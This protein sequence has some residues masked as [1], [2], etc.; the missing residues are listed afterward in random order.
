MVI[1]M[2]GAESKGYLK[3]KELCCTAYNIL[4]KNAHLILNLFCLMVD[5][6]IENIISSN[7]DHFKNIMKV[8]EKF[9]LEL[10]DEEAIIYMQ[11]ILNESEKALFPQIT[12]TFHRCLNYFTKPFRGSILESL[13]KSIFILLDLMKLFPLWMKDLWIVEFRHPF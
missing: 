13:I 12:E 9:K 7:G 2:G 11:S 10:S 5:A 1:G 4:R 3:F 6:N 8:Q